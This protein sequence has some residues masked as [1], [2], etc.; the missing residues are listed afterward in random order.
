ML[1]LIFLCVSIIFVSCNENIQE[2]VSENPPAALTEGEVDTSCE[3]EASQAASV[4]SD[5][6]GASESSEPETSGEISVTIY[7]VKDYKK[8]DLNDFEE[9]EFEVIKAF[10]CKD[11]KVLEKYLLPKEGAFDSFKTIEFGNYAI[12]KDAGSLYFT[13]TVRSSGVDT[14]PPG[15]YSYYVDSLGCWLKPLKKEEITL[16]P[17]QQELSIWFGTCGFYT[18]D[19]YNTL[20]EEKQRL[21]QLDVCDYLLCRYGDLTLE[22]IQKYALD[23]FGLEDLQPQEGGVILYNDGKY[24]IGGHGGEVW[25]KK[26]LGERKENDKTFVTVQFYADVSGFI[27]SCLIEYEMQEKDGNWA[28]LGSKVIEESQYQPFRYSV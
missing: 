10:L 7:D 25:S 15:E 21:F 1:L 23:L 12:T 18:F 3:A 16:T 22:E 13:F 20:N 4:S 26:F 19:D 27:K 6:S 8:L 5:S 2:P 28:F 11:T 17:A 14:L 9:Y 24:S